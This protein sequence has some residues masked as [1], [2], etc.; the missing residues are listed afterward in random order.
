MTR[1][2]QCFALAALACVST[3]TFAP[4]TEAQREPRPDPPAVD[5]TPTRPL[6]P[7]ARIDV[8]LALRQRTQGG[9]SE[10]YRLLEAALVIP[11]AGFRYELATETAPC[12][13]TGEARAADSFAFSCRGDRATQRGSVNVE[14][15]VLTVRLSDQ[16]EGRPQA[17]HLWRLVLP[18]RARVVFHPSEVGLR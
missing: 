4:N 7:G 18:L 6:Q 2:L 15:N 13:C 1:S 12:G 17:D 10:R 5:I 11:Q 8:R 3:V 14:G 9:S 16:F